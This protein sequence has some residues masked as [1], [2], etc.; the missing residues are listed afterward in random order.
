MKKIKYVIFDVDG[1]LTDGR[2]Y[3]GAS[4]EALKAFHVKDGYGIT[5]LL[6]EAGVEPVIITGRTSEIVAK[7]CA[8]LKI[9]RVYQGKMDKLPV[10]LEAVGED[11]LGS[12]AY[13]GDDIP[14]ISCMNRIRE[15]GGYTGCPADAVCQ[16]KCIC[17][18]VSSRNGGDGA[19]REFIEWILK[20]ER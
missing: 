8:D 19:V 5:H 4:G 2:I 14:D 10:L 13:M 18:F 12:C 15:A 3:F 16:V 20:E 1:T 11:G 6:R 9:E 7:R 17:D